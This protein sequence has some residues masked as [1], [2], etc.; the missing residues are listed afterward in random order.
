MTQPGA[1]A[2][3]R[4][5]VTG[6]PANAARGPIPHG[7]SPNGTTALSPS[8]PGSSTPGS[9]AP[10]ANAQGQNGAKA[11][12]GAP[13]AVPGQIGQRP[14]TAAGR[15]GAAT[16]EGGR[17]KPTA[18]SACTDK[19]IS[20]Q[21][22][23]GAESYKV[24]Q[25]PRLQLLVTNVGS[26]PC[27]RNLDPGLQEMVVTGP[28]KSRLWSS[29]DCFPAKRSEVRTLQPG[30]PQVFPVDWAGRTSSPGCAGER[31]SIGPGSYVLTAKLGS[32]S[33]GPARF[34]IVK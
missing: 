32:I 7:L 18:L 23:T 29:N 2:A 25:K 34:T 22:Q 4:A 8:T 16:T 26:T 31:T 21:A 5:P 28:G 11:A 9:S 14:A 15:P 17:A 6:L 10:G 27:T 24:G 3:G 33:S 1:V 12:Q 20:V 13:Q 30:K 19:A